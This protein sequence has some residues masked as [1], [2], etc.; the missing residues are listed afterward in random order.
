MRQYLTFKQGN[1]IRTCGYIDYSK[2]AYI[3]RRSLCHQFHKFGEGFGCS[4]IILNYLRSKGIETIIIVFQERFLRASV[5][6]FYE[7]GERYTDNRD[8]QLIL[9]FRHFK[10]I[11]NVEEKQEKLLENI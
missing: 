8:K 3:S 9:P 6:S 4:T 2:Q 7:F 1:G 10:I 11:G 5:Q